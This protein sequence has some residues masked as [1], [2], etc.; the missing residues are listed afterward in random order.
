LP[1]LFAQR[2]VKTD[3]VSHQVETGVNPQPWHRAVTV[4]FLAATFLPNDRPKLIELT[5]N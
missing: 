4:D 5:I 1:P 2:L 3:Y